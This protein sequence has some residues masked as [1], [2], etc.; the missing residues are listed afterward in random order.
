MERRFLILIA[1]VIAAGSGTVLGA[2][3]LAPTVAG[4]ALTAPLA[5]VVALALLLA[6]R[7]RK[8]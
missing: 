5:L 4:A 8:G 1:G 3:L 2:A 6:Q 7:W